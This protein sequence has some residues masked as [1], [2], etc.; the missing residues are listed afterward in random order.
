MNPVRGL[1]VFVSPWQSVCVSIA[2]SR[3]IFYPLDFSDYDIMTSSHD[4]RTY[5]LAPRF[6]VFLSSL[7]P[8]NPLHGVQDPVGGIT[9]FC[10]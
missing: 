5:L 10:T 8:V 2:S 1:D 9:R 6:C 7:G 3:I 4:M